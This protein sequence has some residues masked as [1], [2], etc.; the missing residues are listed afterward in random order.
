MN[1]MF[2][3]ARDAL[4]SGNLIEG[5]TAH[6]RQISPPRMPGER[7]ILRASR[8]VPGLTRNGS[9]SSR[10][11][12]C[13]MGSWENDD[14]SIQVPSDFFG[15]ILATGGQRNCHPYGLFN[16]SGLALRC[17]VRYGSS[18]QLKHRRV[19]SL[20]LPDRRVVEPIGR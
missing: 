15:Q 20:A 19:C 17:R 16:P 10:V 1:T 13:P 18:C 6:T 11:T 14:C 4:T 3:V 2:E 5:G 12:S 7:L 8:S 9:D